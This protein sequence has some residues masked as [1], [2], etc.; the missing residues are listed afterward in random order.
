VLLWGRRDGVVGGTGAHFAS[1]LGSAPWCQTRACMLT[2][3]IRAPQFS[4]LEKLLCTQFT[5]LS[6]SSCSA[7]SASGP[8]IRLEC[9]EASCFPKA[10]PSVL[11]LTASAK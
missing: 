2:V 5:K 11:L 10:I 3:I 4:G 8:L 9:F 7:G 6:A 1:D